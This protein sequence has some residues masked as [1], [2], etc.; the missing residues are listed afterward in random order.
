MFR[1]TGKSG[2]IDVEY[3][4]PEGVK[5][6][7]YDFDFDDI[8]ES[9]KLKPGHVDFLARKI[10]PL[11]T[12]DRGYVWLWGSASRIG[13]AAYNMALSDVRVKRVAAYLM[14]RS[15]TAGQM[16]VNAIGNELTAQH[17]L[18]DEHDRAVILVAHPKTKDDPPPPPRKAPPR[19]KQPVSK[20]FAIALM[21]G[22]SVSLSVLVLKALAE[23]KIG[24]GPGVDLM[25]FIIWD[26]TNNLMCIYVF[27]A[28]SAVLGLGSLPP[29]SMTTHGP[30]NYFTTEKEIS[31][32]QFGRG[33][34]FGSLS[35][36]MPDPRNPGSLISLN[37]LGIDTP[38]GV[39][40]VHMWIDTGTT[41]GLGL[42]RSIGAEFFRTD[43][44]RPFKGP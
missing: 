27:V 12:D 31:I 5:V 1:A 7:L 9:I 32:T 36:P 34:S 15:V 17:T 2:K 30:W 3:W 39:K 11:L 4:E 43:G 14:T 25:F 16:V 21:S 42:S 24:I 18:D 41:I 26:T 13:D 6:W 29:I 22:F 35:V 38:P 28:L 8:D 19:P 20:Q 33:A 10:L 44:P 23:L 37:R 40:N